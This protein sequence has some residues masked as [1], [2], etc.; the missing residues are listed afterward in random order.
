MCVMCVGVYVVY[1]CDVYGVCICEWCVCVMC[2]GMY[3]VY[4][5][6]VCDVCMVCVCL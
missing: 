3:V 4:V 1:V 6:Y 5:V 2:V